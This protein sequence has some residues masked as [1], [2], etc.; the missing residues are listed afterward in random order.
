MAN[1]LIWQARER[2]VWDTNRLMLVALKHAFY[3]FEDL[4]ITDF[5]GEKTIYNFFFLLEN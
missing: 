3:Y 1:F 2:Q 4:F 5:A